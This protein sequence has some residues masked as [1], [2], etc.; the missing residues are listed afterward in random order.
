LKALNE[1]AVRS[2]ILQLESAVVFQ[3]GRERES[4]RDGERERGR[5]KREGLAD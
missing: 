5:G 1:S 3:R 4:D 2:R